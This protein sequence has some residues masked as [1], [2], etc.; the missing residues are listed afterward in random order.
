MIA[1]F[2][3]HKFE[4]FFN[5]FF[6]TENAVSI[7]SMPICW[8]L[9]R[10]LPSLCSFYFR[11][12]PLVRLQETN[13]VALSLLKDRGRWTGF[14]CEQTSHFCW[15]VERVL[16]LHK[17]PP[18]TTPCCIWAQCDL[19]PVWPLLT[20]EGDKVTIGVSWL[21]SGYPLTST[22]RG[23]WGSCHRWVRRES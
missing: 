21:P 20:T 4:G 10:T 5:E 17:V 15:R 23:I 13:R 14:L 6:P 19:G 18:E 16:G 9:R 8:C 11:W 1:L 3:C 12:L 22:W 7:W 2:F